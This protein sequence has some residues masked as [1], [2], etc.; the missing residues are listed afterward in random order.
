VGGTG[1]AESASTGPDEPRRKSSG[2][3]A[4]YLIFALFLLFLI[5]FDA[6]VAYQGEWANF[7]GITVFMLL[8]LTIPTGA[9]KRVRRVLRDQAQ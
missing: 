6:Q 1:V 4:G 9:A 7:A 5:V 2:A 8:F 3:W